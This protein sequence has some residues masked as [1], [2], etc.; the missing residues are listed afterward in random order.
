MTLSLGRGLYTFQEAARLT[1]L[2]DSR[3]REWFRGRLSRSGRK[4]VFAGDYAPVEGDSAISFYD[5]IDVY[6]AGQLRDHGVSLQTVRKL[7][8]R[9]QENLG[10][11]H[12]FC[13]KELLTDGKTV[14]TRGLDGKGREELIEVLTRQGIFPQVLLPFLKAIDYDKVSLL[15]RRWRITPKVVIDPEICFGAPVIEAAGI[16]TAILAA[17]YEANKHNAEL[18]AR[19][20][21]V[22]P[23][24]ILAAADFESTR[25]A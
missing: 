20:Y 10:A 14:F 9:M 24:H 19:W 3:I 7:Y 6:V 16:P 21:N 15:A 1:G 11:A 12:P 5:L 17:A 2:K 4:P 18:V 25:A 13:R 23:Q 8:G 22:R